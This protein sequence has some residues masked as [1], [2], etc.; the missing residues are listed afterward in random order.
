MAVIVVDVFEVA[1]EE[2][3]IRYVEMHPGLE[4]LDLDGAGDPAYHDEGG[5]L[6][7]YVKPGANATAIAEELQR[8]KRTM[9]RVV[10]IK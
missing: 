1:Y 3:L 4:T 6:W 8:Q 7:I 2:S 9:L 10:E 5:Y